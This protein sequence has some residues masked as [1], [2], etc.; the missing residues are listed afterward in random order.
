MTRV[1]SYQL[2]MK[3]RFQKKR[4][5]KKIGKC[6]VIYKIVGK[7]NTEE[8]EDKDIKQTILLIHQC[9]NLRVLVTSRSFCMISVD[10]SPL[11]GF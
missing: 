5:E 7:K 4:K 8:K 2:M 10:A 11:E 9:K 3:S 1:N 6:F